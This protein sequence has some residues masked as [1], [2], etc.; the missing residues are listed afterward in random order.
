MTDDGNKCK[1]S[2]IRENVRGLAA[3]GAYKTGN[4]VPPSQAL[5]ING[6]QNSRKAGV[7]LAVSASILT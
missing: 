3:E 6:E 1:H 4:M 7:A 5:G 2:L